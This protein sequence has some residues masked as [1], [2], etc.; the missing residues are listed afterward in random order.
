VHKTA[1]AK[2]NVRWPGVKGAQ[3]LPSVYGFAKQGR[4]KKNAKGLFL[5][6]I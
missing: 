3:I 5:A 4:L 6:L 1:I 2:Y